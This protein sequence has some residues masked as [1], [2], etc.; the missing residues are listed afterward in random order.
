MVPVAESASLADFIEE[1]AD[2]R[3][4][5]ADFGIGEASGSESRR[6]GA[7]GSPPVALTIARGEHGDPDGDG[8]SLNPTPPV[9]LKVSGRLGRRR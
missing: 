3:Q 6:G 2:S 7:G 4:P 5:L 8:F 1:L 9:A